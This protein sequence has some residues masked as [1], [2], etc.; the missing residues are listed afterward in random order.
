MPKELVIYCD[1]SLKDGAIYG[2]FFGGVMCPSHSLEYVISVLD[3]ATSE[4]NLN[5]EIKW[6]KIT[7]NYKE[8]YIA[9]MDVFFDLV[10]EGH[11]KGRVFFIKNTDKHDSR[12]YTKEQREHQFFYLYYQFIKWSFGLS[13]A[14]TGVQP[15]RVRIMFDELPDTKKKCDRFKKFICGLPSVDNFRH[16]VITEDDLSEV[17]SKKHILLQCIDVVMGSM[18][19]RLNKMHLEKPKGASRRGKRT[20]AKEQVYKHINSRIRRVYANFNIGVTTSVHG[21]FDNRWKHQYRHWKFEP[22]PPKA[23]N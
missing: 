9:L 11:L 15:K 12:L 10:E 6:N 16:L 2:D 18:Q 5:A 23:K 3:K 7:D 14:T 19:F 4:L 1:E 17:D 20:I 13:Y 21:D 8:K 22:T